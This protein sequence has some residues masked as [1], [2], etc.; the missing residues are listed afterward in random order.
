[1][2][3]VNSDV[4]VLRLANFS[5]GDD[6][7]NPSLTL[8]ADK[9]EYTIK[10]PE[11]IAAKGKCFIKVI[12]GFMGL[13]FKADG[14]ERI[15]PDDTRAV[16]WSSNIPYLG[17]DIENR[18]SNNAILA[19]AAVPLNTEKIVTINSVES[20]T[21]TCPS[22]P[23]QVSIKKFFIS[24]NEAATSGQLKP[25]NLYTTDLVPAEI[26]LEI[27]FDEDMSVMTNREMNSMR[28]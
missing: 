2:A 9:N 15:V 5:N 13:S 18:G 11:R 19:S 27:T 17:F 12:S 8:D 26:V 24:N 28:N 16:F 4:Y 10:I 3:N 25:A 23:Q 20:R 7:N 22:L 14:E 1:M 6:P 21:F